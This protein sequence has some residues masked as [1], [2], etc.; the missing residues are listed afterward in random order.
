MAAEGKVHMDHHGYGGHLRVVWS[1]G[2]SAGW[3]L[4]TTL[5]GATP[6]WVLQTL[7]N[8][9]AKTS[10]LLNPVIYIFTSST[11]PP[12]HHSLR[13]DGNA[14][15]P[16]QRPEG[17]GI[18]LLTIINSR[19]VTRM[20]DMTRHVVMSFLML[21]AAESFLV[22][23]THDESLQVALNAIEQL[24]SRLQDVTSRLQASEA[25]L[26]AYFIWYDDWVLVFRAAQGIEKSV[27]DTWTA[28]GRH[29]D[30]PITRL[31]LPCGCTSVNGS[32]PCD[33]HYRS[34]ILDTWPS[35]SIDQVKLV[36]YDRGVEK[37]HVTFRGT[38]STNMSWF[39]LDRVVE[40]S[41][42]DLTPAASVN[43]FSIDG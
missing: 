33:R 9:L 18:K 43:Y 24:N 28:A 41:W 1:P 37:A 23:D 35:L 42:D 27:Y 8:L 13:Q 26:K 39:S 30:D 10:C 12:A 2:D 38:G 6:L 22:D 17:T 21:M 19:P 7:P 40:S 5:G 31:T 34:R 11:Y 25:A 3:G 16:R 14:R 15:G 20:A 29:D 4:W 36:V 32:L